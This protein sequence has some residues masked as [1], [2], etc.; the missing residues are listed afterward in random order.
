M[1]DWPACGDV[2]LVFNAHEIYFEQS[3]LGPKLQAAYRKLERRYIRAVDLFFTV[4]DAIA[5]LLWRAIR[6]ASVGLVQRH[7]H[8]LAAALAAPGSGCKRADLPSE[9]RVVLFQGWF[10]PQR[11]LVTLIRPPN[12]CPTTRPGPDRLR[13]LRDRTPRLLAGKPWSGR[14]RFLGKAEPEEILGLTAGADLGIVP[15]QPIDLNHRF[16]SPNKFFEFVQ[17]GV[18]VVAHDLVFFRDMGRHYGVVAVGDLSTPSGTAAAIRSVLDDRPRWQADA[19]RLP[20]SRGN[21]Q[22]GNRSPAARRRLRARL[23]PSVSEERAAH[24]RVVMLTMDVQIDRRILQ[25]A[26]TL[27]DEGHEVILLACAAE[28]RPRF[29]II[30]RVKVK[31]LDP[32]RPGPPPRKLCQPFGFY[33]AAAA[34]SWLMRLAETRRCSPHAALDRDPSRLG[35]GRPPRPPR[36][37]RGA[38]AGFPASSPPVVPIRCAAGSKPSPGALSSTSPT[39]FTYTICRCSKW[40]PRASGPSYAAGLRRPRD[41]TRPSPG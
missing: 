32:S 41:R 14:V 31:T 20:E 40:P 38:C 15:Y 27:I 4:N 19:G 33:A 24:M 1:P 36:L 17:T 29:E 8:P 35:R 26:E 10:S 34:W 11:N 25:E 16:C 28:G 13:P 9:T 22:L 7:R 30:G 39:C 5:D 18:P 12:S 23:L 37:C 6:K 2:P 21:P 3:D